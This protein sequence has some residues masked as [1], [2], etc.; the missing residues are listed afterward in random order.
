MQFHEWVNGNKFFNL[1]GV[2]HKPHTLEEA[3]EMIHKLA[4]KPPR[5]AGEKIMLT[6]IKD[7]SARPRTGQAHYR[8]ADDRVQVTRALIADAIDGIR[9]YQKAR[10]KA[11]KRCNAEPRVWLVGVLSGNV[12][13][14]S[15]SKAITIAYLPVIAGTKQQAKSL[16]L[17]WTKKQ[18]TDFDL[19]PSAP[20]EQAWWPKLLVAA[21]R[22]IVARLSVKMND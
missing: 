2:K 19:C 9:R 13:P 10:Q 15:E 3:A 17:K 21:K 18:V 16:Y 22:R 11:I 12:H 1:V 5:R 14:W 8:G 20:V 4:G 7:F 6:E